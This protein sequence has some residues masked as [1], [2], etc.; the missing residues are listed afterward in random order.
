MKHAL[1]GLFAVVLSMFTTTVLAQTLNLPASGGNQVASV[2]QG[3]GPV[4]VTIDYASPDVTGPNGEDRTDKIWGTL[5]PYG[6]SS[7]G[8]FGSCGEKCPW[9]AGANKNTVF[10]VTHDVVVQG[11]KLK[12]GAYG[13]HMIPGE[14]RWTVIFSS[15]TQAWGSYFYD[16]K[17]DVLRVNVTPRAHVFTNWLTYEFIDRQP[18]RATV[19]LRWEKLEVPFN[20]TVPKVNELHLATIR[21]E[22][23]GPAGFTDSAWRNAAQFCL[24]NKVGLKEGLTWAEAAVRAPFIG[25]QSFQ[26]L[27]VLASLQE[28]NG[29]ATVAK[30]TVD[31]AMKQSDASAISIHQYGR[32]LMT[33]GRNKRALEVFQ[34]NA[35]KHG[36]VWPTH[37]GLTRGYSALGD[38]EKALEHAQ[39]AHAQAPDALNKKN[40]E[41]MIETLKQGKPVG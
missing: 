38:Y 10:T 4:R 24:Q 29:Q 18:D 7:S 26:N 20:I 6:M 1:T 32:S 11:Q 40:L 19:A 31:D 36:D 14:K 25:K 28:A 27:T 17:D 8:G 22:L 33:Q 23:T 9:R 35:K 3:I 39:K 30:K 13:L 15:N 5:V 37:V 41:Q 34:L 21:D 16:K 2:T 12:A